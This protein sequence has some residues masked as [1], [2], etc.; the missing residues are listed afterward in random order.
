MSAP[1]YTDEELMRFADGELDDAT[2]ARIER[3]LETDDTLLAR[4]AM[5]IE[6]RAAAQSALKPMLDEPVPE[7]LRSAVEAMVASKKAET[8]STSNIIALKRPAP[9]AASPWRL[10]LAAS[11]AAAIGLAAGYSIGALDQTTPAGGIEIASVDRTE[12][13]QALSQ[14]ASGAERALGAPDTRFRA[15]ATFSDESAATCREFEVDRADHTVVAIACHRP[16]AWSVEF[17]VVAPR[18]GDGYAP[19][20]SMEAVEAYLTAINAAPPMSPDEESTALAAI[21]PN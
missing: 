4:L 6:T 14:V 11:V 16:L 15:I 5:F 9:A 7:A 10:A 12:L 13:A 1:G 19:A 20:S 8:R 17:A 21:P 2:R 18:G 3:A